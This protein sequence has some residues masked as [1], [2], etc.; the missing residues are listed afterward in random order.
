MIEKFHL[1]DDTSSPATKKSEP[2]T[3]TWQKLSDDFE[4]RGSLPLLI[5]RDRTKEDESS[6]EGQDVAL[7]LKDSYIDPNKY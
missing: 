3:I 5:G 4:N 6:D 7:G 1:R 2:A